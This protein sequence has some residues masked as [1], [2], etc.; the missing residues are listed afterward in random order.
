M[1]CYFVV[2]DEPTDDGSGDGPYR[3]AEIDEESLRLL[4]G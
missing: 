4:D 2:F 3:G 1:T